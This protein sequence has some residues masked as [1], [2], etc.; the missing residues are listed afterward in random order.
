M[1]IGRNAGDNITIGGNNV[2]LGAACRIMP[3]TEINNNCIVAAGSILAGKYNDLDDAYISVSEALKSAGYFFDRKVEIV[4]ID[5]EKIEDN[6]SEIWDLLKGCFGVVVPG[7][8][9]AR[10]IEGKII[11]AQYCREHKVP[12]LGLCLGSQIMAIEAAR[13]LAGLEDANSERN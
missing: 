4:W 12:Y 7:G 6:D 8:F 2:Y 11:V 1:L 5:A 10:G 13:N 3:G 9:G